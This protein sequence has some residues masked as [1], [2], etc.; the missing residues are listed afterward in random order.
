MKKV[1]S[2][3]LAGLLLFCVLSSGLAEDPILAFGEGEPDILGKPFPDFTVTDTRTN[4]FSLSGALKDHEAVFITCFASWCGSCIRELPLLNEVYKQ[5]GDRV[6]FIGLDFEPED[7]L[8]DIANIRIENKVSFPM[9]KTAGTGLNEYLGFWRLPQN[10]VIDRFG[11]LCFLHDNVFESAEELARALDV[12][13]GDDYTESR[14][15]T[16]TPM[17]ASTR[18]FPVSGALTYYVD[19]ESAR[20]VIFRYNDEEGSFE[21]GYIVPDDIARLRF[22]IS[23]AEQPADMFYFCQADADL[24]QH[25]LPSLLDPDRNAYVYEQPM[26]LLTCGRRFVQGCWQSLTDA[27]SMVSILLFPDE[28][29]VEE[30]M[31]WVREGIPGISWEYAEEEE[32]GTSGLEAYTLHFVDQYS[33]PV[34]DVKVNFCTDAACTLQ[35]ADEN[36][37]VRFSAPVENYHVQLLKVPEGYSFDPGFEL[38]TGDAFGE[39]NILVH[40]D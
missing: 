39:W 15:L 12:F 9:G 25:A 32:P 17:Q 13:V 11:N 6:A 10:L 30:F 28:E 2:I 16:Y 20:K 31:D 8:L 5:Y 19:N 37:L 21:F 36:G 34:P 22:E 27:Q 7:T 29:G 23:P 18:A 40:K 38:F 35:I 4:E 3:L 33:D 14:I 24:S 1:L 26:N